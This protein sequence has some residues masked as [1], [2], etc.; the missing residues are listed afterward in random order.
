MR[1]RATGDFRDG[2]PDLADCRMVAV[3]SSSLGARGLSKL[4][5]VD[6][7]AFAVVWCQS[8]INA[9]RFIERTPLQELLTDH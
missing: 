7:A 2:L 1:N 6:V 8:L 3:R 5:V 9:L 4:L